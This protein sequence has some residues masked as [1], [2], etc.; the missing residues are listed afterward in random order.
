MA[1]TDLSSIEQLTES[2]N[3]SEVRPQLYF[4]HSTRCGISK[5]ALK[6]F[7]KSEVLNLS[8]ADFFL[9]DLLNHRNI[10]NE[11]AAISGVEH[12]SPQVVLVHQKRVIYSESHG[13][14]DGKRIIE[15]L[16]NLQ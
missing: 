15:I 10:S 6:E 11:I 12:Q 1:W 3:H 9:L 8:K 13:T 4:K 14:I 16:E 7:E 2:Y 5:M